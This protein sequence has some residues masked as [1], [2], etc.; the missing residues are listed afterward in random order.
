ML[1][2]IS[3]NIETISF[4]ISTSMKSSHRPLINHID[5]LIRLPDISLVI[6]ITFAHC[7]NLSISSAFFMPSGKCHSVSQ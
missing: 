1:Y 3:G 5:Q 4:Q 6:I 2:R 7:F